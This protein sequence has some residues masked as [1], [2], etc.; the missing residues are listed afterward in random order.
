VHAT[1]DFRKEPFLQPCPEFLLHC[2][3]LMPWLAALALTSVAPARCELLTRM[4]RM[5]LHAQVHA[6]KAVTGPTNHTQPHT[7][8]QALYRSPMR[9]VRIKA[10]QR[11]TTMHWTPPLMAFTKQHHA[12]HSQSLLT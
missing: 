8:K 3:R 7:R 5:A 4:Q 2:K 9:A 6:S 12:G 10:N 1:F 11:A